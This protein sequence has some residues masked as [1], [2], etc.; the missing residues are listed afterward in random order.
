MGEFAFDRDILDLEDGVVGRP[1][2]GDL[3]ALAAPALPRADRFACYFERDGATCAAAGIGG[4]H[5]VLLNFPGA[6]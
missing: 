3:L 4:G 1:A 2:G 6:P 5:G